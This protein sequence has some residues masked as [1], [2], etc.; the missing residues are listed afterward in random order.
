AGAVD[1]VGVKEDDGRAVRGGTAPAQVAAVVG[2]VPQDQR[3]RQRAGEV[4][5]VDEVEGM[6]GEPAQVAVE[7]A[8]DTAV[9]AV[10]LRG[11]QVRLYA[12]RHNSL[13]RFRVVSY[14][15]QQLRS[16]PARTG[17]RWSATPWPASSCFRLVGCRVEGSGGFPGFP[18]Y[19]REKRKK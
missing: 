18:P 5:R 11:L 17:R 10:D 9:G 6:V 19:A 7:V 4:G 12:I 2:Q 8:G 3:R 16:M 15:T 14:S 13:P 1:Q